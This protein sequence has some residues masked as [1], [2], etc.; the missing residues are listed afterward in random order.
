MIPKLSEMTFDQKIGMVLCAR[1]CGYAAEF[2]ETLELIKK[3]AVGCVQIPLNAKTEEYVRRIREVADYPVLIINDMEQ[4][5]PLSEY[6]RIPA[7]VL[8][9]T[10]NKEYVRSFAKGIVS[11]AKKLG[12]DGIWGPVVDI[13]QVNSPGSVA[14]LFGDTPRQNLKR[15]GRNK[16]S[17]R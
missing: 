8:S 5:N 14:R 3:R 15:Y 4:G 13:H 9:A 11:S 17:I 6:P 10:N 2:E 12:F 16:Q 1:R 7:I